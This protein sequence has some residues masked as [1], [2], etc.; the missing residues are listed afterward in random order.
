MAIAASS[1][2]TAWSA[3]IATTTD[4]P[5]QCQAGSIRVTWDGTA[6]VGDGLKLEM[7]QMIVVP[8]GVTFRWAPANEQRSVV[9]YEE[10]GV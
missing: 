9:F 4:T 1:D 2:S 5:I 6:A 3:G 7:G 10:F 8:G